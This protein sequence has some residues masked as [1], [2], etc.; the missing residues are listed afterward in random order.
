MPRDGLESTSARYSVYGGV[1]Q[2]E[3]LANCS[4]VAAYKGKPGHGCFDR[5]ETPKLPTYIAY[6]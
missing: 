6:L 1:L 5:C 3:R 4:T 2:S